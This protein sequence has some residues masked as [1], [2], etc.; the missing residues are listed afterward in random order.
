MSN[1]DFSDKCKDILDKKKK[2]ALYRLSVLCPVSD[3]PFVVIPI[4][5]VLSPLTMKFLH[6][7]RIQPR[8]TRIVFINAIGFGF[9][10]NYNYANLYSFSFFFFIFLKRVDELMEIMLA[11]SGGH[12]KVGCLLALGGNGSQIKTKM[13]WMDR[14]D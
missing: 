12:I 11:N 7:R 8:I 2:V 3:R 6:L 4:P 1:L 14:R 9:L 13:R 5:F 10:N